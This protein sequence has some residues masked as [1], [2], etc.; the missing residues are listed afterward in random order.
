[1]FLFILGIC[2]IFTGLVTHSGVLSGF[3]VLMFLGGIVGAKPVRSRF[4]S[5]THRLSERKRNVPRRRWFRSRRGTS[6]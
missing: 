1:M 6:S 3:G 5:L 4:R 2:Y